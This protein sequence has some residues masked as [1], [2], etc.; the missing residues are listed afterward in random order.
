M[1]KAKIVTFHQKIP[2]FQVQSTS[3]VLLEELSRHF[4]QVI[5]FMNL[6][7]LAKNIFMQFISLTLSLSNLILQHNCLTVIIGKKG[8]QA[9][10]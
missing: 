5:W 8:C 6:W 9:A 10:C 4:T 3:S 7:A 2:S 1:R